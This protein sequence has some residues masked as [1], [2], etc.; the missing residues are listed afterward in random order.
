MSSCFFGAFLSEVQ[1]GYRNYE[2]CKSFT[3]SNMNKIG[4][5]FRKRDKEHFPF[6]I[7]GMTEVRNAKKSYSRD[8][9]AVSK[10]RSPKKRLLC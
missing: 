6:P 8:K 9:F 4:H 7:N 10:G 1:F 5:V 3:V 2:I